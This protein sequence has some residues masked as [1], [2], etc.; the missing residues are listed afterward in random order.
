MGKKNHKN[1]SPQPTALFFF[2]FL[3]SLAR[4]KAHFLVGPSCNCDLDRLVCDAVSTKSPSQLIIALARGLIFWSLGAWSSGPLQ[5]SVASA[6]FNASLAVLEADGTSNF[7][8]GLLLK[9]QFGA[10]STAQGSYHNP[11]FRAGE[12]A[13]VR[14]LRIG[15]LRDRLFIQQH[16][17]FFR[18]H[19]SLNSRA[20]RHG[21]VRA[22]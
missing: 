20:L 3:L 18:F 11:T 16:R 21:L 12:P 22:G 9:Q 10:F 1:S 7:V 6:H 19:L 15:Y 5:C 13:T 4:H 8:Q 2:S 17:L 14:A